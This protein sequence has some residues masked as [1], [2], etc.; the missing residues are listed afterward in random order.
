M[1]TPFRL[2]ACAEMLWK[3]QP[4]AWRCRKLTELGFDVGLWNWTAHDVDALAASGARFSIMNG[5]LRG[6]LADP[7][8]AQELLLTARETAHIGKRLGVARLNLLGMAL[9]IPGSTPIPRE[10]VTGAMWLNARDTLLRIVDLAEELDVTFAL[11]NL[12]TAVDHPGVPFSRAEDTIALVS[13][14]NHP[15]LTLNLDLYHVQIGEG[16]LT[17][18]C[19]RALPWIGEIQ[20]ADVPGRHEPGTGEVNWSGIARALAAMGYTGTIT[21][22]AW[23]ATT[24]EAALDAF[25][26]A[27]TL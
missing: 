8:G 7:A 10:S 24:S 18:V 5:F 23:P 11:E 15:R 2:A 3:D 26:A 4:I 21:L 6:N 22:E 12:N 9:G 19:R 16:N 27:F 17:E 20:I 13:S 14:I 1:P 25:R